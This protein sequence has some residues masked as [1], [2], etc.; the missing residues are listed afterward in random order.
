MCVAV[1]RV[2]QTHTSVA[3]NN[4]EDVDIIVPQAFDNFF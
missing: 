1:Y 4:V 2:R 3:T